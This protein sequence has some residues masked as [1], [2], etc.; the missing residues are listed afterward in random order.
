MIKIMKSTTIVESTIINMF[1]LQKIT[2]GNISSAAPPAVSTGLLPWQPTTK[3]KHLGIQWIILEGSWNRGTPKA[4]ILIGFS[5]LNCYKPSIF[6]VPT[7]METYL[8][9]L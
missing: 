4:S 3:L 6:G 9:D 1:F 7:F 2:T 8:T 5:T